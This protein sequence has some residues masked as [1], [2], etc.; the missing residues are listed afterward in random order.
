MAK[1]NIHVQ[2]FNFSEYHLPEGNSGEGYC[3]YALFVGFLEAP[4][5]PL[6]EKDAGQK[7][8]LVR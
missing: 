5:W 2:R 4:D 3:F 8:S 6:R 7:G 1:Q